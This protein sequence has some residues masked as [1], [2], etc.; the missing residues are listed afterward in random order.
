MTENEIRQ[1]VVTTAKKYLGCRESDGSHRQF[2]DKYNSFQPL[3]RN[4]RMTYTAAWCATF[5]SAI[6]IE[7]GL[8]DII[9][10]ECGCGYMISLYKKLGR[11]QES[12]SY[13]PKAGDVIFYDWQDG[14]D[15]ATTDNTGSPQHVGIVTAAADGIISVIEGNKADAVAFRS[16]AVN[17]RYIRGYGLP[18]YA[19]KATP[20]VK[21]APKPSV[22]KCPY[23]EPT[24]DLRRG[25]KGNGVKWV[26]WYLNHAA[27]EKLKV[28]GDFG[29]L[30]RATVLRFQKKQK[31]TQD[32]IVGAKTRA[33]LRKAVG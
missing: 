28:D 18:D 23:A 31:L 11:W 21:P 27:G 7:C 10:V 12:D 25:S 13:V 29:I 15:Y 19:S 33:A 14:A 32:G 17:G 16:I 22:K 26:Q 30:T 20:E 2:I 24:K 5:V 8:T 9:P 4:H 1:K 3:P 6:A